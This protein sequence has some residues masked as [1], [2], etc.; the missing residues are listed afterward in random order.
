V[1][2][3]RAGGPRGSHHPASGIWLAQSRGAES[4]TTV[5]PFWIASISKQFGAVA[6]LKLAESRQLS[7]QDSLPRFFPNA[8]VDKR[9]IRLEQLLDHT[10]GLARRY[11]AD[12]IADR[13]SAV[14][15]ILSIPLDRPHGQAFG[16]SNDAYTLVAAIVEIESGRSYERY[17]ADNLLAPA[18]LHHTGFWGPREHP[19]VAPIRGAFTDRANIRP[20]WGFRVLHV[21][22]PLSLE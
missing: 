8:P 17:L 3:I 18:G 16:Y 12:G 7:L 15:A 22:R 6:V 4:V 21:R 9:G 20:N 2:W 11:A 19:E 14:A 10:A 5:T 1:G 13:D